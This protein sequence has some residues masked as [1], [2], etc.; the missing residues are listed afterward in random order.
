[1]SKV[2]VMEKRDVAK[3]VLEILDTGEVSQATIAD[4]TGISKTALNQWLRGKYIGDNQSVQRRIEQW[5]VA[6]EERRNL[7]LPQAPTWFETATA[8]KVM[9]VLTYAQMA[10][11]IAVVHGAA[12]VGKTITAESYRDTRP[13][14]W[15]A[16]MS[17]STKNVRACLQRVARA[18]G[19]RNAVNNYMSTAILKEQVEEVV[20]NSKGLLII[21]EAQHLA[22]DALEELR[23]IYDTAK[24]TVGLVFM[25]NDTVYV[26]ISGQTRKAAFAQLYSRIGR[27]IHLKTVLAADVDALIKAWEIKDGDVRKLVRN[28][29]AQAG[30]LRGVTKTLR[31]AQLAASQTDGSLNADLVRHAHAEMQGA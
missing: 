12:G 23:S 28:L 6:R 13:N 18:I 15:I 10:G 7:G 11:D 25:G 24:G 5:L 9:S 1:M 2:V 3:E 19:I 14:A 22:P 27:R 17:P 31:L 20:T 21:D 29:S 30:A 8:R 4:E 16:T 26:K